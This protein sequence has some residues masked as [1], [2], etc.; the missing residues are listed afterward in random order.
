MTKIWTGANWKL[1]DNKCNEDIYLW[2]A[3]WKNIVG[4]GKIAG[5]ENGYEY[6]ALF[7]VEIVCFMHYH[8]KITIHCHAAEK[9]EKLKWNF[10]SCNNCFSRIHLRNHDLW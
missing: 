2:K 4:K 9:S 6:P 8:V 3:L 5:Y 10:S 1:P 7:K